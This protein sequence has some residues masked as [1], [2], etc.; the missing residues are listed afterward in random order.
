MLK[1]GNYFYYALTNGMFYFSFGVFACVLSIYLADRGCSATEISLIS[2]AGSLFGMAIQPLCGMLADRIKS[3]KYV[4]IA[5]MVFAAVFGV[6]FSTTS[7]L[8]FLFLFN[9]MCQGILNSIVSLNDR[10]SIASA[11]S[12]GSIRIWGSVLYA[13]ACQIAGLV[14]E[15][16]SPESVFYIFALGMVLSLI[17]SLGIHDVKEEGIKREEKF[18]FRELGKALFKNKDFL[19]FLIIYILFTGPTNAN[20]VYMPLLIQQLGGSATMLGTIMLLSTLSE[21]PVVLFI[22][23]IVEKISYKKL[24][25]IACFFSIVRYGWYA[26]TPAPD[27][28]MYVFFFPGITSIIFILISV[29]II[30]EIVDEHYVN[31]AFGISSMLAKGGSTLV[32]LLL[33]GQIVDRFPGNTGFAITYGMYALVMVITLLLVLRFKFNK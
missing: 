7:N 11:Y 28:I 25:I 10:L 1:K 27:L 16:I 33:S 5:C 24:M 14:Y 15:H 13:V 17:G 26:M 9:G 6:L 32:F 3:P 23:K 4:C 31:S 21:L 30:V 20:S 12:Y 19:L 18:T 29:K 2:S 22:D 8:V